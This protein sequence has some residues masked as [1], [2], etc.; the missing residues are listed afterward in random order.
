MAA[1][2][3]VKKWTQP[4]GSDGNTGRDES[5]GRRRR[6]KRDGGGK[7]D[8]PSPGAS[9]P[10]LRRRTQVA[11]AL[12]RSSLARPDRSARGARCGAW[13]IETERAESLVYGMNETDE[14]VII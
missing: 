4:S 6:P 8:G 3:G 1:H 9:R 10:G 11:T 2:G 14:T 13:R 12:P 5:R 7:S